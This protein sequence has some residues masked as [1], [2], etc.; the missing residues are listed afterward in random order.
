MKIIL[1]HNHYRQPGG[2]DCVVRDEENLLRSNGHEVIRFTRDSNS[3]KGRGGIKTAIGS[4]WNSRTARELR[5]LVKVER[6]N[7]VHFHNTVPMI[8]PAAYWAARSAGA[9][10]VQSIH[11]YRQIC[12]K[13]TFV[14]EG[15]VCEDCQG[16]A[17]A[18]PAIKNK[19]YRESR[20]GSATLATGAFVHRMMGTY[21]RKVDR[22]IAM[23]QFAK[24][25]SVAGGLPEHLIDVK[26][27]FVIPDP[28]LSNSYSQHAIF[29]GRLSEE[30]GVDTLLEAWRQLGDEIPL[31]IIGDGPMSQ[32]VLRA[33]K[34]NRA[35]HWCGQQPWEH[36]IDEI[37]KARVLV[38]PSNCFETFGRSMVEAFAKGTPV[39][40]SKLGSMAEI[41]DDGRTG[42]HFN[43]G[44]A[45]D[46]AA[47]VRHL[48]DEPFRLEMMRREARLEYEMHYTAKTNYE[49]LMEIY[50]RAI[51]TRQRDWPV[52]EQCQ[53]DKSAASV[54]ESLVGIGGLETP[55]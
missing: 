36:V 15:K 30:K 12:P 33:T 23:T 7:I 8:S 34:E 32:Q 38:F 9:A 20:L 54:A 41:I 16:K 55:T 6:A 2:E 5:E 51:E 48:C 28:G 50:D 31:K 39:I 25:R 21:R 35:I 19:C 14:R 17:F 13:G 40:G 1:C 29:V 18:W 3:I 42:C 45:D 24:L 4:I 43:P 46:L 27:N 11:N 47:K 52:G 26:P 49:L 22:Y 10:V 37:G 53:R 44:D